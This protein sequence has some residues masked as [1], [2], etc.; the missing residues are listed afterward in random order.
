M[1]IVGVLICVVAVVVIALTIT[2]R[3]K[4]T[5]VAQSEVRSTRT[6]TKH[7]VG[8]QNA[9]SPAFEPSSKSIRTASDLDKYL[10]TVEGE[11]GLVLGSFNIP[12]ERLAT[13]KKLLAERKAAFADL[14]E[15]RGSRDQSVMYGARVASDKVDNDFKKEIQTALTP[16]EWQNVGR[17]LEIERTLFGVEHEIANPLIVSGDPLSGSQLF[18]VA[19]LLDAK[20]GKPLGDRG[21]VAAPVDPTSRL[22]KWDENLLGKLDGNFSTSQVARVKAVLASYNESAHSR[23]SGFGA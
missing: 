18:L 14:A 20:F 8:A 22:T 19:D 15:L 23:G 17:M 4:H 7:A 16:A 10:K 13:I 2:N 6:D 5:A 9:Q 12:S 3:R 21:D 11:Y 1:L